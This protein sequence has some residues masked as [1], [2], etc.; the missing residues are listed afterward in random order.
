MHAGHGWERRWSRAWAG[1]TEAERATV[2]A[3]AER[4]AVL[5]VPVAAGEPHEL[6]QDVEHTVTLGLRSPL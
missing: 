4:T 3:E 5:V 1:A 2:F 6:L